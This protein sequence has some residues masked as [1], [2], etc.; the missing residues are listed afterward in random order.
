[1]IGARSPFP[2]YLP[3]RAPVINPPYP[4]NVVLNAG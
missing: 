2:T 3:T 1:M 4:L